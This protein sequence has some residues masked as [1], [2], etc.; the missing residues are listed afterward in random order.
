[1]KDP[2]LR[3]PL[4][5]GLILVAAFIAAWLPASPVQ[6]GRAAQDGVSSYDTPVMPPDAELCIGPYSNFNNPHLAGPEDP[7][8]VVIELEEPPAIEAFRRERSAETRVGRANPRAIAAARAQMARIN[9]AQQRLVAALD[10]PRF[11]ARITG[12]VQRVYNGV[13]ARVASGR[14]SEVLALPGVKAVH[15]PELIYPATDTSVPFIGAHRVWDPSLQGGYRGEGVTIAVIDSGIDYTHAN[16]GGSGSSSV[17]NSNNPRVIGDIADF[18]N[19]KVIGGVDLVGDNYNAADPNNNIPNPDPDPVDCRGNGHGTAVAG[20]AAGIGVNIDGSAYTGAYNQNTNFSSFRIGP[21]MAPRAHLFALRVFGC[22]ASGAASNAVVTQAIDYAMD[23]NQDGDFS[24]RARVVILPGGGPFSTLPNSP[25]ITAINNGAQLNVIYVGPLGN[26]GDTHLAAGGPALAEGAL[27]VVANADNGLFTQNIRVNSPANIAGI[28]TSSVTEFGFPLDV[29]YTRPAVRA[30]PNDG[31]APLTNGSQV[32][33]NIA[34]VDFGA[35][36]PTTKARNAQAA[37]AVAAI[38]AN[39]TAALPVNVRDDGTGSDITIPSFLISQTGGDA[40]RQALTGGQTVN[41]SLTPGDVTAQSGLA[42]NY[43]SFNPYGGV[44]FSSRGPTTTND[45]LKPDIS[46][47]GVNIGSA[48]VGSGNNFYYFSGTSAAAPH[49]AGTAALLA[50]KFPDATSRA[51]YDIIRSTSTGVFSGANSAPPERSPSLVGGGGINA[52]GAIKTVASVN[53]SQTDTA[54]NLYGEIIQVLGLQTLLRRVRFARFAAEE[55]NINVTLNTIAAIPGVNVTIPNP[56]GTVPPNSIF[57]ISYVTNI[58][59]LALKRQCAPWVSP[60]QANNPRHCLS[61]SE[62]FSTYG[63]FPDGPTPI[64]APGSFVVRPASQMGA[65]QTSINLAN[66]TGAILL[67]LIGQGV[68]NGPT[69]PTDWRSFV[70]PFELQWIDPNDALTPPDL[71]HFDLQYVGVRKAGE[72]LII[73]A[74]TYGDWRSHNELRFN[75]FIDINRDGRDDFHLFNTSLPNAQGAPSDVPVTRLFNINT[76][77]FAPQTFFLNSFSPATLDSALY[78][79]NVATLPV[80]VSLLGGSLGKFDYTVK[81]SFGNVIIN[82]SARLTYDAANPGLDF[83]ASTMFND[84]PGV[85]I[86][87]TYNLNNFR[88]ANSEGALLFHHFNTHGNRAQVLPA[89]QGLEGDIDGDGELTHNDVVIASLMAIA[90]E[91]LKL[92]NEFQR[93]D[94]APRGDKGDGRIRLSDVVQNGRYV[95]GFDPPTS[96]GGPIEPASGSSQF[97]GQTASSLGSEAGQTRTL[98]ALNASFVAGQTNTLDIELD[99]LGGENAAAFTL[100]F[101]PTA[102]SFVSAA[103]GAATSAAEIAVNNTQAASGRIGVLVALPA[104]QS[105]QAGARRIATVR[106]NIAP[107]SSA[108]TTTVS[109]NDQIIARQLANANADEL[110]V[111]TTD[112]MVTIARAVA[113][114]SAASFTGAALASESIVA[115]FGTALATS[116]EVATS[117]P[118]PTNLAGTT[119]NVRDSAGVDRLASLFFV[120]SGQINYAMPVGV[121]LGAAT[122]TITSGS[123]AISVG[124]VRIEAV[125]PGLFAANATGQG[126]AAAQVLRVKADGEQVFEPTAV[127]DAELGRFVAAPIDLG[128][129]EEQVFLVLFGTGVRFR[130]DLAAVQL[131]V[132]GTNLEALYAGPQGVF[133]GLDQLN[134]LLPRSLAGRGTVQVVLAVDG[135]P[136]NVVEISVR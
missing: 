113:S 9:Q 65:Q 71:D 63:Y 82:E 51:I 118:L 131:T 89:N 53:N 43:A 62:F 2:K 119:V 112:A 37:G 64:R 133:V 108:N 100:N 13:M 98:R 17:F 99:A 55:A 130:S 35:C 24:D 87:T 76:Q 32:N 80:D 91:P 123:G 36:S 101:D 44:Y 34:F 136:A 16:L 84:L 28:Y 75:V 30:T 132:G 27:G 115:A 49:V 125:A 25:V 105:L 8:E 72:R 52:E 23:P 26:G 78:Y 97:V 40:I 81:T 79:T 88:A 69:L 46:A 93:V 96:A 116:T 129:P 11:N 60:T 120:S 90:V 124:N 59:P 127:F 103:V 135:K 50:Q 6:S 109:F 15:F 3:S 22:N 66:P 54:T 73:G 114:V 67:N 117:V 106:F 4:F 33:G 57:D 58:D 122:V 20:I 14:L 5:A 42:N 92:G 134:A 45:I 86:P 41:I 83:G 77:T 110:M 39:N 94:T 128:P 61:Q 19:L 48:R 95:G 85:T 21:G 47:P 7:V 10:A 38:I 107:G 31:C 12:R 56:T 111:S 29:S 104:G 1:M 68:N 121:A 74:S 18:P 102:L 70:S 126:V